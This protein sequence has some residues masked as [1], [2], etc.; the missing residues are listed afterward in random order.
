MMEILDECIA[1]IN[2]TTTI[3]GAW[4]AFKRSVRRIVGHRVR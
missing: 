3:T 1:D 2:S 4:Q